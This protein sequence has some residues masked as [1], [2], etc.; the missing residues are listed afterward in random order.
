MA[1]RKVE[2]PKGSWLDK[3]GQRWMKVAIDVMIG[4]G[5]FLRQI[6]M[7]FPVNFEMAL[8]KYMVDMG[9]MN[10]FRD[11]VNQQYPSLKRLRNLTFFPMGN[12]VLRK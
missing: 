7:T 6:T 10:D 9:D 3:K 4:G 2:I 1:K 12:K 8:G 5:K 11:R